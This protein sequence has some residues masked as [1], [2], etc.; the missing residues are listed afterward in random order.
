MKTCPK[1]QHLQHHLQKKT[2]EKREEI[3]HKPKKCVIFAL[4]K[5][6]WVK[7]EFQPTELKFF[8]FYPTQT[9]RH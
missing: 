4:E 6:R 9:K 5:T 7:K 8:L 3:A 2:N 1:N